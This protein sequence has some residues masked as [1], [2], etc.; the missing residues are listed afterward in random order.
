[1]LLGIRPNKFSMLGTLLLLFSQISW[2]SSFYDEVNDR[3]LVFLSEGERN[4]RAYFCRPYLEGI[5]KQLYL[6]QVNKIEN[7]PFCREITTKFLPIKD[8][9]IAKIYR[10]RSLPKALQGR[11][12]TELI[13]ELKSNN[14]HSL[15]PS[16]FD[17]L[18]N[19]MESNFNRRN[20]IVKSKVTTFRLRVQERTP[21]QA[22]LNPNAPHTTCTASLIKIRGE[23][24]LFTNEHC[25]QSK[26][27]FMNLDIPE[28]SS[29]SVEVYEDN[30]A[31]EWDIMTLKLPATVRDEFCPHLEDQD[32]KEL[33]QQALN[34]PK[35]FYSLGYS[36][37][38]GHTRLDI[39]SSEVDD[40][41]YQG[42]DT[43]RGSFRRSTKLEFPNGRADIYNYIPTYRGM[44]GGVLTD[45]DG[46]PICL[47]H[48]TVPQQDTPQCV[49]LVDLNRFVEGTLPRANPEDNLLNP[50][51][52]Q[53]TYDRFDLNKEL[54]DPLSNKVAPGNSYISPGNTSIPPGNTS[55][56]PGN[57]SIPPGN[58]SI[59]PG[60]TSIPPGNTSI[61][62]G[63]PLRINIPAITDYLK[64][65]VCWDK[66]LNAVDPSASLGEFVEALEGIVDHNDSDKREI[67]AV[68]CGP[69]S[70]WEQIDG[71]EDYVHKLVPYNRATRACPNI[72]NLSE[73]D[74]IYRDKDGLVP[75]SHRLG[76]LERLN[77][78]FFTH[79]EKTA[80]RLLKYDELP[81]EG[82]HL[83]AK[84]RKA[85]HHRVSVNSEEETVA[86]QLGGPA[87]PFS[88]DVI[89]A[90]FKVSFVDDGKKI[91]LKPDYTGGIYPGSQ[92]LGEMTCDNK[93]FLKLICKGPT[94]AL[95]ISVTNNL[96]KRVAVRFSSFDKNS[97][98]F[99]HTHGDLYENF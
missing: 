21:N 61:P 33:T 1:M 56:P 57:T 7:L 85:V 13:S 74:K 36:G 8:S 25:A 53:R 84:E 10:N 66:N 92:T 23:C 69:F 22:S 76:L 16:D 17:E 50:E 97:R 41:R 28:L 79:D 46:S 62:P 52:F 4:Q 31:T 67:L 86:I 93:N 51:L 98:E 6:S 20:S 71:Q 89:T 45:E 32:Q 27:A 95:S 70:P 38:S 19:L 40:V 64:N 5:K 24:H 82:N 73:R 43:R 35:A 14:Y 99:I 75:M 54:N 63:N 80:G 94:S 72:S 2:A 48:R 81:S 91:I 29:T 18:F 42:E 78:T 58:T 96:D 11:G 9:D 44:S 90:E 55:I 60:N 15:S 77:G 12:S 68:R 59:P 88:N 49:S 3:G 65:T 26:N 83:T 39:F 30:V 37:R 87:G 47:I 34:P